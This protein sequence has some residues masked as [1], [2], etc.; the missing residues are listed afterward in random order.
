MNFHVDTDEFD[1]DR[2]RVSLYFDWDETYEATQ[3]QDGAT[4]VIDDTTLLTLYH[5]LKR[6]Y[7]QA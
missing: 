2:Q 1:N 3:D 7:N 6:Y 4:V 5:V